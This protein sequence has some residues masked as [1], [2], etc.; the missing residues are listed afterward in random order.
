MRTAATMVGAA[1]LVAAATVTVSQATAMAQG[2]HKVVYTVTT[3]SELNA[4]IYYM[5]TQ[6]PS[7]ADFN[8]NSSQYLPSVKV[9]VNP[10]APW[11]FETTLDDP[12]AW[13]IV[14]A[15]GALRENPQFHCQIA[16]DD[17]VVVNQDAGSGV[18]CRMPGSQV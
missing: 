8:A 14:T 17:V 7:K 16:V 4:T 5:A 10:G 18:Q 15:S 6:P 12:D 13:A 1:A 9:N 3:A 2:A 11:V